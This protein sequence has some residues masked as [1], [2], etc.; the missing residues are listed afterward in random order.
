MN[1]FKLLWTAA[2]RRTRRDLLY[3]VAL[4]GTAEL[5][6][7]GL[8]GVSGWFL[9]ACAVVTAQANT[10]WSWMYP[11]GA[12]RALA[13]SRTGLRYAERLVSH[14][15]CWARLSRCAPGWSAPRPPCRRVNCATGATAP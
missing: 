10:T 11:S 9:T 12:V 5:C 14:G 4:A 2:D 15:P 6:A 13:L 8:L 3:A 7:A 1:A